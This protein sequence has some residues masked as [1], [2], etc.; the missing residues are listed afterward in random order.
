MKQFTQPNNALQY[1]PAKGFRIHLL[2][3]L[4]TIPLLWIGWYIS[5]QPYPWPVWNSIAWGTGL[6]FHYLGIT[7]FKQFKQ[8]KNTTK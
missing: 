6:A 5:E 8:Q 1:N 2:V 7:R 3:F 4:L